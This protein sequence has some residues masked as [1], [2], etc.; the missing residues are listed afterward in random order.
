MIHTSR[1]GWRIFKLENKDQEAEA[2]DLYPCR[3]HLTTQPLNALYLLGVPNSSQV[4][5]LK[6]SCFGYKCI[7]SLLG[8]LNGSTWAV[9]LTDADW[10]QLNPH[11][12]FQ[13]YASYLSILSCTEEVILNCK[14]DVMSS[15]N[16]T[17]MRAFWN[18]FLNYRSSQ[19]YETL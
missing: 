15:T 11:T 17:N 4:L 1:I 14:C 2:V 7:T 10:K 13:V 18:A 5:I 19:Y 9:V 12:P 8:A 3:L 16:I 6:T